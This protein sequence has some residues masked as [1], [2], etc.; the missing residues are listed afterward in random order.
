VSVEFTMPARAEGG[1]QLSVQRSIVNRLDGADPDAVWLITGASDAFGRLLAMAALRCHRRV[2]AT[3]KRL[4]DLELLASDSQRQLTPVE[5]D[6]NDESADLEVVNHAFDTF[7][8]ID[9]VVNNAG[10]ENWNRELTRRE[11]TWRVQTNL[12]GALWISQYATALMQSAGRGQI[13]QVFV[14]HEV[15][16][17]STPALFDRARHTLESFSASLAREIAPF[18]LHVSIGSRMDRATQRTVGSVGECQTIRLLDPAAVTGIA[19][20]GA[21]VNC[22]KKDLVV[23]RYQISR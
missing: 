20:S 3:S 18:G 15:D 8:R 5:L 4:A 7:G 22:I 16:R 1:E 2:V 14:P 19:L 12:F 13:V 10:Y 21:K 23:R 11:M 9:V 6:V 17:D